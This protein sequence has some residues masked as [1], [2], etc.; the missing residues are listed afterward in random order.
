MKQHHIDFK[1]ITLIAMNIDSIHIED[2]Q[3]CTTVQYYVGLDKVSF[4]TR[5]VGFC[6][7]EGMKF[8]KTES[9]V[10]VQRAFRIKIGCQPPN[11]SNIFRGYISLK[12]LAVFVKGK[13]R[14]DQGC[15]M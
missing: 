4:A 8:T 1:N 5:F 10:T 12:Q 3:W 15:I 6:Y 9:A 7:A 14:D 13:V 11:D 2:V